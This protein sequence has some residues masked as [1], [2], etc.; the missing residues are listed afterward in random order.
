MKKRIKIFFISTLLL[1]AVILAFFGWRYLSGANNS[2]KEIAASFVPPKGAVRGVEEEAYPSEM[3]NEKYR[4]PQV[5]FGGGLTS[6]FPG[7]G[8][9]LGPLDISDVRSE[10]LKTKDK[11]GIKL[12]V[13]WETRR[14]TKCSVEYAKG[15]GQGKSI[16]EDY[17]S[18]SHSAIFS[19]LESASTYNYIITAKDKLGGE[20]MSDKFAVYTGAPEIS[21]LDLLAGAFKDVFGWAVKK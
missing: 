11:K 1:T 13:N 20:A 15:E 18:V 6:F 21:L 7:L 19:D 8:E 17:F 3:K 16:A 5:A 4:L 12:V 14:P 2:S 10:I 9:P